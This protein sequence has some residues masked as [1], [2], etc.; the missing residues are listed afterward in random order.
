MAA[1]FA[2][3]YW[4][5]I[6]FDNT[7]ANNVVRQTGKWLDTNNIRH[8]IMNQFHHLASQE[9]SLT[10]LVTLRNNGAGHFCKVTDIGCGVEMTAFLQVLRLQPFLPSQ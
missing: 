7:L 5:R 3:G 4:R 1:I 2:F 6:S 10:S 8:A 9:P